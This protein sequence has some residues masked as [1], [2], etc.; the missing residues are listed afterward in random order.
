MSEES[1]GQNGASRLDQLEKIVE[2]LRDSHLLLLEQSLKVLRW[3]QTLLQD[4]Q[5]GP[6]QLE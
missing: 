5:D 2:R 6:G 4:P 1:N 3:S